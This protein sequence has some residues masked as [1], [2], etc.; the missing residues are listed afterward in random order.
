MRKD[1]NNLHIATLTIANPLK[2]CT[3]SSEKEK[4][5]YHHEPIPIQKVEICKITPSMLTTEDILQCRLSSA[6]GLTH[7]H[8]RINSK[9]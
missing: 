1:I 8:K 2:N 3:R 6:D 5:H 9:V 7:N 4:Q